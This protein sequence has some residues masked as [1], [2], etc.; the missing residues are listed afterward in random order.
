MLGILVAINLVFVCPAATAG[1]E[2]G[3]SPAFANG[4]K[5]AYSI[6]VGRDASDAELLAVAE[7]SMYLGRVTGTVTDATLKTYYGNGPIAEGCETNKNRCIY[8]GWTEFAKANGLDGAAMKPE[9][10]RHSRR[11]IIQS[12]PLNAGD[13]ASNEFDD[14]AVTFAFFQAPD[15]HDPAGI[16]QIRYQRINLTVF[17]Y[18]YT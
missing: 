3:K 12:S 2:V 7:L 6:V 10:G 15:R 13:I 1:P 9:A 4:G 11:V 16:F 17:L 5:A 8:L 14:K 18:R